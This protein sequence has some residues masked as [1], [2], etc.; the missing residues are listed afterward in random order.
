MID[1]GP[2]A[3]WWAFGV[4]GHAGNLAALP[5]RGADARIT[6]SQRHPERGFDPHHALDTFPQSPGRPL[7]WSATNLLTRAL[8]RCQIDPHH[9]E[10]MMRKAWLAVPAMALCL[11][12]AA[13]AASAQEVFRLEDFWKMADTDKDGMMTKQEFMDAAGKRFDAM[14]A[15]MKKM[16]ADKGKMMM[17][18]DM[19][20]KEGFK[21]FLD[22]WKTFN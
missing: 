3:R 8:A 15:K 22:E 6:F 12:L 4:R 1:A 18:G 14:M 11:G 7:R 19:M 5:R 17:K 16:P 9:V 20:T 2:N 10:M 13:P 21:L